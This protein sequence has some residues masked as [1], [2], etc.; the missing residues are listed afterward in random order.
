MFELGEYHLEFIIPLLYIL[1]DDLGEGDEAM[2][3]GVQR[4]CE[5]IFASR[6]SKE[7]TWT[8]LL[9]CCFK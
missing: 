2:F 3:Q 6:S 5:L 8:K 7:T 4:L 9:K 1:K